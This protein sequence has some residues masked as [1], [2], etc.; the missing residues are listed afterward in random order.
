MSSITP[1]HGSPVEI[2][3]VTWPDCTLHTGDEDQRCWTCKA[4]GLP[5]DMALPVCR[6][7]RSQNR[8]CGGYGLRAR[9]P[10]IAMLDQSESPA[11]ASTLASYQL[12][13][14]GLPP[15]Q[16]FYL[17]HLS[18]NLARIGLATD[19]EGNGYRKWIR[20][21]TSDS[22][23][24]D[25]ILAVAISHYAR[26]QRQTSLNDSQTH[27]RQALR[28]LRD[29]L[30]DPVMVRNESTLAAMMF[31][32]TYEV[33]NGSD[34]WKR[35]QAGVLAWIT[36]F[37]SQTSLDPFLKI[38]LSMVN[39]QAALNSGIP[40]AP[41]V[42]AWLGGL[43]PQRAISVIDPF[44]G[45][46]AS[47]PALMLQAS[48][49]Y[50]AYRTAAM[51]DE[52]IDEATRR[53]VEDLKQQLSTTRIELDSPLAFELTCAAPGEALSPI[54]YFA[55]N[56]IFTRALAVAEIF[57]YAMLIYVLRI[58]NPPGHTLVPEIQQAVLSVMDLLPLVPDVL[59]PGA[60]LGWAYVVVG[61]ELE[62]EERREYIWSRLQGLHSL[63]LAN[64]FAAEKVLKAAWRNRDEA[65][66]GREQY[67]DWQ[68]L[69][70]GL[71]ID[72]ILI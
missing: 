54:Q 49:T 47:L 8:A 38:W 34:R 39:T 36:A 32:I 55:R 35:H 65:R 45:C 50:I 67:R 20:V 14:V 18:T 68:Q 48:N 64:V 57:R 19:Y 46:S 10:F 15:K 30:Q 1:A 4:H 40:T 29:R 23:L 53:K 13:Q 60:N 21:A 26:W 52:P 9:W 27:H 28:Q 44:F 70:Q 22:L 59:G 42:A 43:H 63:A 7:C 6:S 31:L 24:L 12:S 66:L 69:M 11:L 3:R 62:D 72:Q 25:T 61:V 33:F 16:S 2:P 17:Q 56:E 58:L 51:S 5:C 37:G 71:N 41:Q